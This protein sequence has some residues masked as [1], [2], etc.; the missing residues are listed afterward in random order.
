MNHEGDHVFGD[1]E[2]LESTRAKTINTQIKQF[3]PAQFRSTRIRLVYFGEHGDSEQARYT[4]PA[5]T[6]IGFFYGSVS[7]SNKFYFGNASMNYYLFHYHVYVMGDDFTPEE[8]PDNYSIFAAKYRFD[9]SNY[10][11]FEEGGG[12]NDINDIVF[13]IHNTWPPETDL[14]PNDFPVATPKEWI[15]ACEDLGSTDD[16]DFNDIVL[17][18]NHISGE[19]MITIRPLACGGGWKGA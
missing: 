12:D 2:N 15:V 11:G 7:G 3:R 18:V 9:G 4:F 8:K 16:Y 6:R 5:G 1:W 14:T 19:N 13:R 10:V 17:A